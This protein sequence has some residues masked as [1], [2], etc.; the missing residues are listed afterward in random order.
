[1]NCKIW[2][3]GLMMLQACGLR[4]QC[5]LKTA[6]FTEFPNSTIQ[7]VTVK[8]LLTLPDSILPKISWENSFTQTLEIN[9]FQYP[10]DIY[11]KGS[12][13]NP[14]KPQTQ[15][16]FHQD[17]MINVNGVI[18]DTNSL[19]SIFIHHFFALPFG[20]VTDS[21]CVV[22]IEREPETTYRQV[23]Q[24]IERIAD[25]Y[26]LGLEQYKKQNGEKLSCKKY[27]DFKEELHQMYLTKGYI[28]IDRVFEQPSLFFRFNLD[29]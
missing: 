1:M 22:E 14:G 24:R 7:K 26:L 13:L 10:L 29:E 15:I 11:Y 5:D 28:S 19:D 17:G 27:A 8:E 6:V 21:N 25:A 18:A 2:V 12:S 4:G 23:E 16:L 3:V 9:G 20:E